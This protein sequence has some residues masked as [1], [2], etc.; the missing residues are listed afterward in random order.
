MKT[1]TVA[2][3]KSQFSAVIGDLREGRQVAITYGR[4]KELLATIVPQSKMVQPDYSV[5]VGDLESAG[6]AY[7]LNDFEISDEQL[8]G[9]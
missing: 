8:L 6:W 4:N 1:M 9:A 3:L 2:Q 7:K 5:K